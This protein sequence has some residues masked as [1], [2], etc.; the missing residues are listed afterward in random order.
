MAARRPAA[1]LAAGCAVLV[2]L[3]A[4]CRGVDRAASE[5]PTDRPGTKPQRGGTRTYYSHRV[6][7]HT[8]PQRTYNGRDLTNWSRTVYRSLVSF[9]L[10]DDPAISGTDVPDLATDTGTSED[11]ARTWRFTLRHGVTWE[12][13]RPITCEDLRYGASRVFAT[14]VITGGP[15]YLL[16]YLDIPADPATGRPIYT[17]PYRS[18]AEGRAAFDRA[19]TC[20]GRTITYHFKK[21]WADFPLAIASLHMMDPYRADRDRGAASDGQIFS[22]GPYRLEGSWDSRRGGT[23]VRN[24]GYDPATDS[25]D[26]R[27]ALPDRIVLDL[28]RTEEEINALLIADRGAA[29]TAVT[30]APIP[31]A[32][33][34][35]ITG[36]VAARS[37][38]VQSP[39]VD[40]LLPNF[41]RLPNLLVRQALAASLDV[42]AWVAAGGGGKALRE[43]TDIVNPAVRGYQRDLFPGGSGDPVR[44]RRLLEAAG[45]PLPYPITFTCPRSPTL[46]KQAA[47]IE[48][49]WERAGFGVTL[50]L[51]D[52]DRYLAALQDPRQRGDVL[53]AG[54]G[55]DWPS[56]VTV[57][58][59]LLDSRPSLTATSNGQDHGAYRSPEFE[60]LVDEAE[61]AGDLD[62]QTTLLQ[63]ADQVLADD[64]AYLPL[65]VPVFHFLRGSGVS[66]YVTTV[67]PN[68][69]P[70]LGAVGVAR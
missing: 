68:A 62:T 57:L 66:G 51:V 54:W 50:D 35:R 32:Y 4:G 63:Q 9:P 25:T 31:A 17:G 21:P 64:V 33:E 48:E 46:E 42:T 40:H 27:K 23:L 13:D 47:A 45:V 29:R 30:D 36:R 16:E 28:G 15:R 20:T 44:A 43:A 2:L 18:S 7:E 12:D 37:V 3:L 6:V 11:G 52:G 34:A 56:A 10:S 65:D 59:P 41:R 19:I 69:Y 5:L 1:L 22:N 24:Q 49:G 61:R 67:A 26:L 38:T 8:D 70:D 14:D 53:Y 60:A 39:Y 58:A 55:A